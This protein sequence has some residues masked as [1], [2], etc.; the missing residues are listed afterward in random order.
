MSVIDEDVI[1]TKIYDVDEDKPAQT[2]TTNTNENEEPKQLVIHEKNREIWERKF[3]FPML[4]EDMKKVKKEYGKEGFEKLFNRFKKMSDA[5]IPYKKV[6]TSIV[7]IRTLANKEQSLGEYVFYLANL[8]G[9]QKHFNPENGEITEFESVHL[10]NMPFGYDKKLNLMP[11]YVNNVFKGYKSTSEYNFFLDKFIPNESIDKILE[12]SDMMEGINVRYSFKDMGKDY[13]GYTREELSTLR[14][15]RLR[16]RN[17][18]KE[19]GSD[20]RP[21]DKMTIVTNNTDEYLN[22][23]VS[24][25]GKK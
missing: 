16:S 12:N 20:I 4:A 2:I 25:K 7:R 8:Y 18:K 21:E 15:D 24:K 22:V 14:S 9:Y 11:N 3:V 10:L 19:M 6:V 17:E 23:E 5:S 1:K 13:G